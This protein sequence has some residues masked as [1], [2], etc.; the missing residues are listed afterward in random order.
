MIEVNNLTNIRGDTGSRFDQP[1][2]PGKTH[3]PV[4]GKKGVARR[5]EAAN[6]TAVPGPAAAAAAADG[7]ITTFY[8]ESLDPHSKMTD[9]GS[10]IQMWAA[11]NPSLD[12]IRGCTIKSPEVSLRATTKTHGSLGTK[13]RRGSAFFMQASP[14]STTLGR[15]E[16]V[17]GHDLYLQ[18][19]YERKMRRRDPRH[20]FPKRGEDYIYYNHRSK[21]CYIPRKANKDAL[22]LTYNHMFDFSDGFRFL[23]NGDTEPP[24]PNPSVVNVHTGEFKSLNKT[25]LKKL[26]ESAFLRE[27]Y[28]IPG[29]RPPLTSTRS[30]KYQAAKT[31]SVDLAHSLRV[32]DLRIKPFQKRVNIEDVIAKDSKHVAKVMDGVSSVVAKGKVK[33]NEVPENLRRALS[34]EQVRRTAILDSE[35]ASALTTGHHMGEL[36]SQCYVTELSPVPRSLWRKDEPRLLPLTPEQTPKRQNVSFTDHAD[37]VLLGF[38]ENVGQ[39]VIGKDGGPAYQLK[40]VREEESKEE[41]EK[42]GI[43][44][45]NSMDQTQ[46]Q[47]REAC[48]TQGLPSLPASKEMPVLLPSIAIAAMRDAEWFDPVSLTR[49]KFDEAPPSWSS[50]LPEKPLSFET[51]RLDYIRNYDARSVSPPRAMIHWTQAKTLL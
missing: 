28:S 49:T 50:Q 8:N 46:Q 43:I 17:M 35:K 25:D 13:Y 47:P 31:I 9:E 24:R 19:C 4:V 39:L 10:T 7:A 32:S 21:G 44:R 6:T 15:E 48:T 16:A 38:T 12:G 20:G 2:S 18:L 26:A 11:R 37:R 45:S 5:E 14:M 41:D 22:T 36:G 23:C 30:S 29:H 51:S 42:E 3:L 34:E 27:G 33:L 1:S 40:H